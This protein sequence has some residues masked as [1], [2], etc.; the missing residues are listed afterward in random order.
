MTKN[1]WKKEF[2][3]LKSKN[4]IYF[5][6]AAST[7]KPKSVVRAENDY[8]AFT[9]VNV[10]RGGYQLQLQ[11]EK[12][13]EDTRSLIATFV[14]AKSPKSVVFTKNTTEAISLVVN[15]YLKNNLKKGDEIVV[16]ELEHHSNFLP[17]VALAKQTG[18]KLVILPLNEK[19]KITVADAKK[20]ITP[21]T[22]FVALSQVSNVLGTE[23]PVA[24][25]V[26]LAHKVGAKV[27]VD[28][29]QAVSHRKVN[30]KKLNCD[31]YVFSGYKLYA[32]TGVG[33][34]VG[35]QELLQETQPQ[36]LGGGMVLNADPKNLQ[37][38][39]VPYKFEGGTLPISSILGLQ[40]AIEFLLDVGYA[41]IEKKETVLKN[42]LLQ[43]LAKLEDVKIYS[44]DCAVPV[45]AFNITGVHAH[46]AATLYDEKGIALRAGHHCAQILHKALE[47]PASLRVS[48]AFYNTTQEIDKFI[49]ITKQIIAFFHKK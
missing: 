29:A 11:V 10:G 24:Q 21:K 42:Y 32:P 28:G 7:P 31:F 2:P 44:T 14:G 6:N 38:K 13:V 9:P 33:V 45:V 48:L 35:K 1:I 25:I 16:S 22:K 12:R 46:D 49:H 36:L 4:L 17:Y 15:G 37:W 5:D 39:E 30:L 26:A 19:H 8:N 20:V 27:L 23:Q 40:K 41:E 18:A 34:L 3:M 47:V 43:E